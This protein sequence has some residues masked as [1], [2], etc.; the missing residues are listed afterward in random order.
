MRPLGAGNCCVDSCDCRLHDLRYGVLVFEFYE[1][2]AVPIYLLCFV[3]SLA[4]AW[5]DRRN[6]RLLIPCLVFLGIGFA[7]VPAWVAILMPMLAALTLLLF[8]KT[9][10]HEPFD[11]QKHLLALRDHGILSQ[12]AYEEES[13]R[14][15]GHG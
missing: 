3:V 11:Y 14:I 4:V 10:K 8:R 1:I 13:A 12:A 5:F 9:T 6:A 2:V 15:A 7:P